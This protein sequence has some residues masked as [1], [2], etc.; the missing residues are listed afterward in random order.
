MW[1]T[2]TPLDSG[3]SIGVAPA[4]GSRAQN[5]SQLPPQQNLF[6]LGGRSVQLEGGEDRFW[7]SPIRRLLRVHQSDRS[8]RFR[9]IDGV[10]SG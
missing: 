9:R 3:R 10:G 6:Q 8:S 5:L 7:V 4:E 2:I 1:L